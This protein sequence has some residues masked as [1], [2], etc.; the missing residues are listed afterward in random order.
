MGARFIV[1]TLGKHLD[2][3]KEGMGMQAEQT[4]GAVTDRAEQAR[5]V[6]S[7]QAGEA[8]QR[9]RGFVEQQLDQRSTMLGEQVG[10][11]SQGL[12]RVAEQARQE[13]N[14]QQARLAEQA[15]DRTDR[16]STFLTEADGDR[17]LAEAEEFARRQP[18]VLAGAGLLAGVV[19][20]RAMKV[21]SRRR[22]DTRAGVAPYNGSG[23]GNGAGRWHDHRSE[24][25]PYGGATAGPG[26]EP[27]REL[28]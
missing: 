28:A 23:T 13:G 18:W 7:A 25:A 1:R 15:A 10:S 11:T 6:V 2:S 12:R 24:P 27:F 8:V 26:Q 5:E 21:S 3:S 19:L 9:S 17:L 16:L 22:Y 14:D 4:T 20:A